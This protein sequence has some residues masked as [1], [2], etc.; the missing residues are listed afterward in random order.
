MRGFPSVTELVI[1]FTS[2]KTRRSN[3]SNASSATPDDAHDSLAM[4]EWA[5]GKLTPD[6]RMVFVLHEVEGHTLAEVSA[7]TGVG[8]STL[9]ARLVAGR[10]RLDAALERIGSEPTASLREGGGDIITNLL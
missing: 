9:H 4:A 3:T 1:T 6:Q 10:K 8:I 5:L 2:R 7:M